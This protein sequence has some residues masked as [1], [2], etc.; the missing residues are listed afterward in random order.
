MKNE[1]LSSAARL[2]DQQL[3][4]QVKNLARTEREATV[5]L[6][7]LLAELDE[8]KLYL[9]EGC[10]SLFSYC[11]EI[12]HLSENAAYAR[13]QA[14]RAA[15]KFPV[16][17]AKLAAGSLNL[18]TL[19]LLAPHLKQENYVDL[20]AAAEHKRKRQVEEL[21]AAVRP[22]PAVAASIRKV[23]SHRPSQGTDQV[24]AATG[25]GVAG[26]GALWPAAQE[27]VSTTTTAANAADAASRAAAAAGAAA[28]VMAAEPTEATSGANGAGHV[29]GHGTDRRATPATRPSVTRPSVTPLA[30][31][32]YKVQF[33]ADAE[34]HVMLRRAQEL[35]R[36][37]V[38][39]GDLNVVIGRALSLLVA[40]LEKQKFAALGGGRVATRTAHDTNARSVN[41]EGTHRRSAKRQSPH[42][43]RGQGQR[44]HRPS[45]HGQSAKERNA[46]GRGTHAGSAQGRRASGRGGRR[47]RYIPAAVRRAVWKRDGGRCAFIGSDGRR[48]SELGRI[49]FDHAIPHG[50]S[51]VATIENIQLRCAAHNRYAADLYFGPGTSS[52]RRSRAGTPRTGMPRADT[53]RT[54]TPRAGMPRAGTARVGTPRAGTSR[55]G[56]SRAGTHRADTNTHANETG[57]KTERLAR[58]RDVRP[59]A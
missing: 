29:A 43:G 40:H 42:T 4:V 15:R 54:G 27:A 20:L 24:P 7:A 1:L 53:P 37:Q 52:I 30:P 6:I 34:T 57:A 19:G 47:S 12:L 8:R 14:A 33:T 10:A 51:G 16:V 5:N 59:G 46:H 9:G 44:A 13:I 25:V 49:E 35:L 50:D 21:V 58:V 31:E 48:C 22:R 36:H 18:T 23:Q 55:A 11:V 28:A 26:L 45:E 32:L 3:L 38:P 56:T 39:T 2:T 17:F 41:G